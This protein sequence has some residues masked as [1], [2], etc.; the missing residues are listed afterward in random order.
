VA[1]V[2]AGGYTLYGVSE[3]EGVSETAVEITDAAADPGITD[4]PPRGIALLKE[5]L[6]ELQLLIDRGTP[7]TIIGNKKT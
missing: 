2:A 3:E 4:K 1:T 6:T 5:D 7:V